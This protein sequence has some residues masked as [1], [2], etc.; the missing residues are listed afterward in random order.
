MAPRIPVPAKDEDRV[1]DQREKKWTG[2]RQIW[3][4]RLL[5]SSFALFATVP[6][7]ARGRSSSR[8]HRCRLY[9]RILSDSPQVFLP[10]LC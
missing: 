5:V 8:P 10:S 6:T 4:L 7:I 9:R 1:L 2:V 3:R